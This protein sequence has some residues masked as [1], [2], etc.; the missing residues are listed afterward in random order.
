MATGR[1]GKGAAAS[2]RLPALSRKAALVVVEPGLLLSRFRSLIAALQTVAQSLIVITSPS[3]RR[4]ELEA[5]GVRV[6]DFQFADRARNPLQHVAAAW[7]LAR[8]FEAEHCHLV[9]LIAERPIILGAFALKLATVPHVVLHATGE[10]GIDSD[11]RRRRSFARAASVR[12]F[13]STVRRPSSYLLVENPDELARLRA[14][15]ADPGPR[16]AIL[17]GGGVDPQ[18]FPPLPPPGNAVPVAAYAGSLAKS[19]G[20]DVLLDAYDRVATRGGRLRLELCGSPEPDGADA[21]AAPT[22]SSWCAQRNARLR[23]A[24]A[25]VALWR[26]ADFL[27]LP[28]HSGGSVSRALLEAAACARPII[29]SD[30]PG[31]RYFLRHGV[32][33]LL[34]PPGSVA[35]LAEAMQQLAEDGELRVRMGEAARLRLLHG[36]TEAHVAH[37]LRASYQSLL[38]RAAL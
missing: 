17:G 32:E 21:I 38:G 14:A 22:I 27:V 29:A 8:I 31:A 10:G 23:G 1:R 28:R 25:G 33:G 26:S 9:H 35:A 11:T 20:I 37:V 16:F 7:A 6:I 30:V 2:D 19:Q 13:A 15:G 34:V 5:L 36:F 12:L 24:D 4:G 3:P 18:A